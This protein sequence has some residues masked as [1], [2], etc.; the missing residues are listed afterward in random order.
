M[1]H[2]E[3]KRIALIERL[4]SHESVEDLVREYPEEAALVRELS[5]IVGPLRAD[6]S[7]PERSRFEMMLV[8]ARSQ[9]NGGYFSFFPLRHCAAPALL[10]L[11]LVGGYGYTTLT[12]PRDKA[13]GTE[14]TRTEADTRAAFSAPSAPKAAFMI[15]NESPASGKIFVAGDAMF[16]RAIRTAGERVG[17]DAILAPAASVLSAHEAVV[18]NLEGPVTEAS[19][20][21][22]GSAVGSPQNFVFTFAPEALSA[23]LRQAGADS[24]G[25][26]QV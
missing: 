25:A 19:S 6:I 24:A 3:D 23:E 12:P 16:D 17:Y 7:S 21:S 10:L 26:A 9:K 14:E 8:Q 18:I 11:L 22:E 13:V 15:A 5:D 2:T 20:I 4:L 1:N